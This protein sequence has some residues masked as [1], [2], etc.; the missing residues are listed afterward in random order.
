MLNPEIMK[1]IHVSANIS[2]GESRLRNDQQYHLDAASPARDTFQKTLALIC[3][4]QDSGCRAPVQEQT[5]LSE[6]ERYFREKYAEHKMKTQRGSAGLNMKETCQGRVLLHNASGPKPYIS[7]AIFL[8]RFTSLF[9]FSYTACSISC[10]HYSSD[11]NRAH[12]IQPLDESYDLAYLQA[13]F[14]ED[15]REVNRMEEEAA[16]MGYGPRATCTTTANATS[17][18]LFCRMLIFNQYDECRI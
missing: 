3:A 1:A 2:D 17:Q 7:Y 18:L 16:R 12:L 10:E 5:V 8:P 11:G 15:I 6:K 14:N 9:S 4:L 13:Y